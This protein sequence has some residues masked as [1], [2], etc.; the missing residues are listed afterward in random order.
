VFTSGVTSNVLRKEWKLI[1]RDPNLIAQTLLQVLYGLPLAFVVFRH[2]G[3]VRAVTPLFVLIATTLAGNLAW[4]TVAAEDA[5]ELI[6]SSPVSPKRLAWT[7]VFAA[8]IP[9]WVLVLP[10]IVLAGLQVPLTAMITSCCVLGGT[11]S[12]AAMQVWYPQRG[13]RGD[14]KRR[15]RASLFISLLEFFTGA[16][17]TA[18]A[19]TLL[20][21]LRYA[22]LALLAAII[23]PIVAWH[24]GRARRIAG[25]GAYLP[26]AKR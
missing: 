9:V 19:W 6:A 1:F 16:A 25:T 10:I 3:S 20:F 4:L 22:P 8:V 2:G 12:V 24:F 5:P 21:A 14:L 23:A 18:I 15:A 7:K 26:G 13:Q 17:W 11:L